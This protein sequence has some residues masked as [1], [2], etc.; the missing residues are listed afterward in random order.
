VVNGQ[1]SWEREWKNYYRILGIDRNI[2][3]Q[4]IKRAY[5]NKQKK[6]HPDNFPDTD[7][8]K[9]FYDL[10]E[11][12]DKKVNEAYGIL[13]DPQKRE[14]YDIAWDKRKRSNTENE[15]E[16]KEANTEND[17]SY[18]SPFI[19]PK[20]VVDLPLINF[21]NAEPGEIKKES[22]TITNEGGDFEHIWVDVD[23]PD[24]WVKVVD[25]YSMDVNN[26]VPYKVEIEAEG[27]DWNQNFLEYITVR[28][29]EEETKVRVE[30]HTI[31]NP[32]VESS[33]IKVGKSIILVICVILLLFG[34][35]A[36]TDTIFGHHGTSSPSVISSASPMVTNNSDTNTR[37]AYTNDGVNSGSPS[38]LS[39]SYSGEA[40]CKNRNGKT[41]PFKLTLIGPNIDG[42][43][44]GQIEWP[45]LDSINQIAGSKTTTGI[46]FTE[47]AY[48]KQ[49]GAIL[50]CKYDLNSEGSSFTGTWYSPDTGDYGTISM[51]S[52]MNTK[53]A[54]TSDRVNTN[55]Y[56]DNS[57]ATCTPGSKSAKCS[58][59]DSCVD[60]QGNCVASGT[61]SEEGL[62][63]N[64]GMWSNPLVARTNEY[65][66]NQTSLVNE[67]KKQEPISRI[68]A[69]TISVVSS[70][71]SPNVQRPSSKIRPGY[72]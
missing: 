1:E 17:N 10:A 30:L 54:Y 19:K 31:A 53:T 46:T 13:G 60:C 64:Q 7:Y 35:N 26:Q 36:I 28:L 25:R 16:L 58:S 56:W 12:E 45:S 57:M 21:G 43:I 72:A 37:N 8:P 62:V 11:K 27:K 32:S 18:R 9:S 48:I 63:C 22:F 65:R 14:K 40:I 34:H 42:S 68:P 59:S 51:N 29:D 3:Q 50:N 6:I 24:S 67:P 44:S 61:H 70:N 55:E 66:D 39:N 49:G 2:P 20:P 47:I 52:D 4:E 23:T 69:A 33:Q 5:Y 41:W 38:T 71:P 15:D